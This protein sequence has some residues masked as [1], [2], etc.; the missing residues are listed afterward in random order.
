MSMQHSFDVN[1]AKLYGVEV[2]IF[3][4]NIAY[5]VVYNK[6]EDINYHDGRYWT[7]NKISSFSNH[8]PYWSSKQIERLINKC[9]ALNLIIRGNYNKSKYDRT[10]WY[11]LTE[12]ACKLLNID[13][14]RNR[15]MEIS[16]SGNQSPEIG[17]PI[18]NNKTHIVNTNKRESALTT[19]ED[20]IPDKKAADLCFQR[21][22]SPQNTLDKFKNHHIARGTYVKL[23]DINSE[24][25]NWILNERQSKM[26]C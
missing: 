3:L 13:I 4:K 19:F 9:F 15:E 12:N 7:Y 20:F 18:P 2:A 25:Y 22:L 14:S 16:K 26:G 1:I 6:N 8:F 23:L 10:C 5:W 24:F 21:K 11:S 17:R